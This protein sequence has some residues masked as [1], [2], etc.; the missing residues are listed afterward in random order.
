[1][2]VASGGCTAA[3]TGSDTGAP[4]AYE[5]ITLVS[6]QVTMKPYVHLQGA[7]QDVTVI[8]GYLDITRSRVDRQPALQ[9][10]I[11]KPLSAQNIEFSIENYGWSPAMDAALE[12]R[13]INRDAGTQGPLQRIEI[14]DIS[15]VDQ[16]SFAPALVELGVDVDRLGLSPS[17]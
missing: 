8:G 7:G 16:F 12:F 10:L 6:H 2:I 3:P 15:G 9:S 13:F 4:E 11:L 1:M 14:G 17:I 5:P